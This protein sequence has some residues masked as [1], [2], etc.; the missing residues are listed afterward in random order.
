[1][2]IK[3]GHCSGVH[4]TAAQVRDCYNQGDVL[5]MEELPATD[6]Q[7][8]FAQKLLR[9]RE[10]HEDWE[11]TDDVKVDA[12]GKHTISRF[13]QAMI[14]Q[15]YTKGEAWTLAEPSILAGYYALEDPEDPA[16]I[17]F[18]QVKNED[19]HNNPRRL[20]ILAGAPGSFAKHRVYKSAQ[21][22][23]LMARIAQDPTA[24]FALFG[25]KVGK[26]GVCG[27]PL[28]DQDSRDRGI[29]PVCYG[30]LEA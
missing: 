10:L 25:Q 28:T 19:E 1:M 8:G 30:K 18:L 22:N 14:D 24:A 15:P 3:C 11:G 21:A 6:K 4:E 5:T 16:H 17:V 9:T 27:S 12:M 23:S 13:I 7:K 2:S 26:C 29:G 20:Y